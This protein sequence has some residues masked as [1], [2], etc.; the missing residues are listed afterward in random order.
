MNNCIYL[1][2]TWRKFRVRNTYKAAHDDLTWAMIWPWL[3]IQFQH[4]ESLVRQRTAWAKVSGRTL[5]HFSGC[6]TSGW[7]RGQPGCRT[8]SAISSVLLQKTR[9]SHSDTWTEEACGRSA[10]HTGNA[11]RARLWALGTPYIDTSKVSQAHETCESKAMSTWPQSW[12]PTVILGNTRGGSYMLEKSK[13]WLHLFVEYLDLT[14]K[15]RVSKQKRYVPAT[16][17]NSKLRISPRRSQQVKCGLRRRDGLDEKEGFWFSALFSLHHPFRTLTRSPAITAMTTAVQC[18]PDDSFPL[19]LAC[20]TY[21]YSTLHTPSSQRH[22]RTVP[23]FTNRPSPPHLRSSPLA[24]RGFFSLLRI[25]LTSSL[26]HNPHRP[27]A[28]V[29][30]STKLLE[31][32]I[33]ALVAQHSQACASIIFAFHPAI[34]IQFLYFPSSARYPHVPVGLL[35]ITYHSVSKP[36]LDHI[37]D[38]D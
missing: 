10:Y 3:V 30:R 11:T 28:G 15:H 13:H 35:G 7:D 5:C 19:R 33:I 12:T 38:V 17:H 25:Q 23:L 18:Y 9:R 24:S 4:E 6:L 22:R 37:S 8:L 1:S 31:A 14:S 27:Q 36:V 26:R 32:I 20:S 2:A 16:R 34:W 21:R 29:L